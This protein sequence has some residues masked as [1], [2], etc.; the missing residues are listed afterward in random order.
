[1]SD[2]RYQTY[3]WRD[4]NGTVEPRLNSLLYLEMTDGRPPPDSQKQETATQVFLPEDKGN[5]TNGTDPSVDDFEKFGTFMLKRERF[6]D[7]WL[8]QKLDPINK[9]MTLHVEDT[10]VGVW[11]NVIETKWSWSFSLQLAPSSGINTEFKKRGERYPVFT[12]DPNWS[13][14]AKTW[15]ESFQNPEQ[16]WPG[17]IVWECY[18]VE[19]GPKN[20]SDSS[21][22]A[23]ISTAA[24]GK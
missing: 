16:K 4:K 8:I 18:N 10:T 22:L 2:V 6:M 21:G 5:W 23:K 13:N 15:F 9:L 24:D 20:R 19:W 11:A 12:V 7:D 3:P 14:E 1:M 17:A